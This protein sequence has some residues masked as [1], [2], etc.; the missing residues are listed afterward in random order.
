VHSIVI[1]SNGTIRAENQPG[2]GACLTVT[3]PG[4]PGLR[5]GAQAQETDPRKEAHA[6][7]SR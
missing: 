3:L 1:A 6:H 7:S 2:G 5:E 4:A